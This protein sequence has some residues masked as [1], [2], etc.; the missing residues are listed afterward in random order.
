MKES[1]VAQP[2]KKT[3]NPKIPLIVDCALAILRDQ[4]EQGLAMRKVAAKAGMSLGNLQYYFKNKDE[5]LDGVLDDY[6]QRCGDHYDAAF[7]RCRPEGRDATIRFLAAYGM[8]YA[9]SELGKVFR[10]L[11]GIATRNDRLKG[12]LHEYYRVYAEE[13]A[14]ALAP[15]AG[16][17]DAVARVVSLLI[18]FYDG[19]GLI[20][21]PSPLPLDRQAMIDFLA[22]I[23]DSALNG[24][25]G[26]RRQPQK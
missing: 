1:A 9:D 19:Y 6:F 2:A 26:G 3:T 10:E 23:M 4:G 20:A 22:D 18:P 24:D 8:E 11:W 7:A 21:S 12:H 13:V 5:L 17:P 15:F 16:T 14:K 25:L